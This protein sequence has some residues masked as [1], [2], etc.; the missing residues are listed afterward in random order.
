MEIMVPWADNSKPNW[1][2]IFPREARDVE[3]RGVE[4]SPH[5][6]KGLDMHQNSNI[7]EEEKDTHR[8]ACTA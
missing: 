7:P 2:A 1:K 6:A 3:S 4:Q 8:I 5:T